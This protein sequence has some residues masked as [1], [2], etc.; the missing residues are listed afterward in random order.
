MISV[1]NALAR[2]ESSML[3]EGQPMPFA[4]DDAQTFIN[5]PLGG[6]TNT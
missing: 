6:R 2:N 5:Y 3:D 4:N 1:D